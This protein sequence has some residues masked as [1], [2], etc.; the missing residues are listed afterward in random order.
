MID[1][2]LDDPLGAGER[3]DRLWIVE[4]FG[5]AID[6]DAALGPEVDKEHPHARIGDQVTQAHERAVAVVVRKQKRPVVDHS[7]EPGRA[8]SEVTIEA[9]LVVGRRE[10]EHALGFDELFEARAQHVPD[11][12]DDPLT[13][14]PTPGARVHF[15]LAGVHLVMSS[16]GHEVLSPLGAG[17]KPAPTEASD[18][19][20][21]K[22]D[23]PWLTG[24]SL[25]SPPCAL[26]SSTLIPSGS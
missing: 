25:P 15:E 1:G 22:H 9:A 2:H 4:D 6:T 23:G 17:L 3:G 20:G 21:K 10:K 5:G 19:S 12:L 26:N 24:A 18:Q 7:N 14:Q 13:D 11:V 16:C 8:A